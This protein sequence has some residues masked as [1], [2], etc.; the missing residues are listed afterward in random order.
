MHATIFSMLP[1]FAAQRVGDLK[2]MGR[3]GPGE[4]QGG[5]GGP[6]REGEGQL[7][8]SIVVEALAG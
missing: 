4:G 1:L 3:A 8:N 6:G 2:Y 7:L 5:I